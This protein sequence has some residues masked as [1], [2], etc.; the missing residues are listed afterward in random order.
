[1]WY[2][3]IKNLQNRY[4]WDYLMLYDKKIS[5]FKQHNIWKY[6]KALIKLFD[7]PE[8]IRDWR[9]FEFNLYILENLAKE[10]K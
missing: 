3:T 2:L 8:T 4:S 9:S 1:M 10:N 7:F 6:K 5:F